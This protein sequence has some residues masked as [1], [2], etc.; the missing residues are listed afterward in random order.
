MKKMAGPG[1]KHLGLGKEVIAKCGI[2]KSVC[3]IP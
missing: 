2:M 1:L 3:S